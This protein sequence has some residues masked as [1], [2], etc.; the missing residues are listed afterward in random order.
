MKNI[1]R[2]LTGTQNTQEALYNIPLTLFSPQIQRAYQEFNNIFT[3][4][5]TN[6]LE[7]YKLNSKAL[8]SHMVMKQL[9]EANYVFWDFIPQDLADKIRN[10]NDTNTAL[11]EYEIQNNGQITRKIFELC[12]NH[13]LLSNQQVLLSQTFEAYTNK[14]YN[15]AIVGLFPII[16][17][18]LTN[19]ITE[20]E[21]NKTFLK[22]RCEKLFEK[23]Q[24]EKLGNKKYSI[25]TF[26]KTFQSAKETF[27]ADSDF[28]Q[29]EPEYPNR[30]W[31]IHGRTTRIYTDLDYIK[32][33][34]FLYGII[35]INDLTKET[36]NNI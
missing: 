27:I 15:L 18:A 34:R 11:K 20:F 30:H 32:I 7:T 12:S 3:Q 16:D 31:I 25:I 1:N 36:T 2:K 19:A 14:Q 22:K 26:L 5:N 23:L 6:T 21:R 13:P 24:N 10:A 28:S 9:V 33:L 29:D 35:I 17:V 8:Q 4:L